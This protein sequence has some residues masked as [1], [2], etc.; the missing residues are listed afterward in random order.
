MLNIGVDIERLRNLN[1]GLGQFC[2]HLA[3]NLQS[4][5]S[6]P[7]ELHFYYPKNFSNYIK[8]AKIHTVSFL[9]KLLGVRN[10]ELQLFHCTHQDSHLFANNTP[11]ILTIHDLNFLEKYSNKAKQQQKLKVL[12]QKINKV[13]GITFISNYT[14]E[15][16]Q[17]HLTLPNVPTRVIYNGNCL[18]QSVEAIKPNVTIEANFIF[19]IGIVNSKKNFH[20]LL[21]LIKETNYTLVIAGNKTNS[22]AQDI[23][24]QAEQ[25]SIAH[26]IILLG[27]V[28]ENE[29]LWLYQHCKAFVFPSLAEGFGLPV[30]EAMSVGK[31]VFLSNKT[32]LPEVGGKLAYYWE[33]FESAYLVEVFKKGLLD[34]EMN[35]S[36]KEELITWS[37]QFNWQKTAND[38][39]DFYTEVYNHN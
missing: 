6:T 10:K 26:K 20:V 23:L 8:D 19:T 27:A 39:L 33:N 12:Q 22:Y 37:A 16:V 15:L 7:K 21:P 17:Q 9:D 5:K 31:P 28:T 30:I 38:Y 25:L 11:T 35:S 13:K 3:T 36:R 14:K 34:Y 32:S 18:N 2:W 24:N 1:S 4:G 29:K